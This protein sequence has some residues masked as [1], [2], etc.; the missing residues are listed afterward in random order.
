MGVWI[1]LDNLAPGWLTTSAML[2]LSA[3]FIGASILGL[4]LGLQQVLNDVSKRNPDKIINEI[5]RLDLFSK[6]A[7]DLNVDLNRDAPHVVKDRT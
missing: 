2:S 5:N 3:T 6:V 4:S 7:F 1:F